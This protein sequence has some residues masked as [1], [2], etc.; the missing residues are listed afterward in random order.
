[1]K[2][3]SVIIAALYT[4]GAITNGAWIHD[5]YVKRCHKNVYSKTIFI[6]AGWPLL[7]TMLVLPSPDLIQNGC[8][9]ATPAAEPEGNTGQPEK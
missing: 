3:S 4:L 1:M 6:M 2:T 7:G 8:S 9:G 5:T